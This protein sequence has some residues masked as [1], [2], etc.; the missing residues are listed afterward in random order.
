MEMNALSRG[1]V[2]LCQWLSL[3]AWTRTL[4]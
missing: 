3:T 1:H 2:L 4:N